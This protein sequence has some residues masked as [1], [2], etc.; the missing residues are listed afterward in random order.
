L[1]LSPFFAFSCGNEAVEETVRLVEITS[2]AMAHQIA[3]PLT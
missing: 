3:L 2:V 1:F